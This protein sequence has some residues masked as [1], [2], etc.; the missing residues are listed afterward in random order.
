MAEPPPILFLHGAFSGP[1]VWTTFV[2]PWFAK[3]G[4]RVAVPH[5]PGVAAGSARLQDYVRTA[6]RAASELGG[7]PIVVGHSFGGLVAQHLA[8]R[9][10]V[11]GAVFVS[12]PGPYGLSPSLWQLS[13]R[14][15]DVLAAL[16]VVQGGAGDLLGSDAIRRALFTPETP[17]AWI[18]KIATAPLRPESPQALFDAMT[19]DLPA[20]PFARLT[21]SLAILG[22]QDLF[23]PMS[24]LWTIGV[25]YGAETELF[26]GVAHGLPLDP[27]WKSLVWRINAWIDERAIGQRRLRMLPG[28]A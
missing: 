21:P 17:D 2:A 18:E 23:V 7:D 13:S 20:W 15:P 4:H 5:L 24:D 27:A 10:C 19:W 8:A 12:S 26:R 1:E 11:S 22:D 6:V 3:R 28:A 16:L 14:A 9:R 25:A